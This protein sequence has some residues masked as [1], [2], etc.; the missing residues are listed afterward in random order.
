MPPSAL[1][2]CLTDGL[3]PEDWYEL[4]NGK[5]FFWLDP[6]RLDRQR[7]ACGAAP[8][9]VL[10][11]DAGRLLADYGATAAVAPINSGNA[12]RA[13]ALR[14]RTTFVPYE[15]WRAEGWADERIPGV[16]PRPLHHRPVELVV[17]DAVPNIMAYATAVVPLAA[18]EGMAAALL[19]SAD[20]RK[21]QPSRRHR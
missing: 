1:S 21:R 4:L 2:K 19:R 7:L 5:V 3:E 9:F 6:K 20:G 14:N 12:M 8:Q 18:G 17:S 10:V 15:R 16:N 11:V 13:A